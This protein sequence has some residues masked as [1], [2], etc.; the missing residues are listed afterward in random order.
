MALVDVIVPLYN[1]RPD[2]LDEAL[3]S[4]SSQSMAD[5]RA[6]VVNDGSTDRSFEPVLD[7]H[8]DLISYIE[9]TNSGVAGARNSGLR[10][11]GAK[12]VAFL[13]QD[14]RWRRDKIEKQLAA[15][16]GGSAADVVIHPVTQVDGE[17]RPR[18][19]NASKERELRRR[20]RSK[21]MLSA[22]LRGNF[23]YSPTV[24]A[25]RSCFD[26]VG[27]FDP[28][29]EPHDDWDMWLRLAIA[30]FVFR[31][32]EEPLADWRVHPGNTS[33]DKD[34][35]LKTKMKVIEKL[36]AEA[37]LPR[38]LKPA[39]IR[40]QAECHVTLAHHHFRSGRYRS[41]REEITEAAAIDWRA[42]IKLKILRRWIRS[43]LL[44]NK[45]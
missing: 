12:L 27:G 33:R 4:L 25:K 16:D 37:L 21:D 20:R 10:A 34:L 45:G 30:G 35:M 3:T 31:T 1:P 44:E 18:A 8:G 6:I 9:Q 15:M 39:L 42:A 24:L 41:F 32:V 29:V 17:G 43:A 7:K 11:A 19:H 28:S 5:V 2:Y 36:K 14:D 23:I 40:A 13:D 22:L 26:E 38:R